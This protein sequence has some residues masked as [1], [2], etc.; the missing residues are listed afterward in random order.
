MNNF[1]RKKNPKPI[2]VVQKNYIEIFD[3]EIFFHGNGRVMTLTELIDLKE[4][5]DKLEKTVYAAS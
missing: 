1:N 2:Q 3:G 5:L 4:R